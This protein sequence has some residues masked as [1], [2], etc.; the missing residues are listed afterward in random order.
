MEDEDNF[1]FDMI[2]NNNTIVENKNSIKLNKDLNNSSS[3]KAQNAIIRAKSLFK[4]KKINLKK[5]RNKVFNNNK[6]KI[7]LSEKKPSTKKKDDESEEGKI[8]ECH[9][10]MCEKVFNDKN[11]YRKHLIIHG[12]KQFVCQAEGCGK[13]FLDNSKLKRHMLVHTGLKAYKCELCNKRFSL[14]FNLR[15]HLRIHTGEKPYVCSFEGC[16]KRFSQSSNLSAHEKTH[17]LTKLEEANNNTT[18]N[19]FNLGFKNNLN[20]L[21]DANNTNISYIHI[22]PANI[23]SFLFPHKRKL[24]KICQ[25]YNEENSEKHKKPAV[26]LDKDRYE[27]KLKELED[28]KKEFELIKK[29]YLLEKTNEY[30]ERHNLLAFSNNNNNDN[31]IAESINENIYS[32]TNNNTTKDNLVNQSL[33]INDSNVKDSDENNQNNSNKTNKELNFLLSSLDY[34]IEKRINNKHFE[35]QVED[36]IDNEKVCYYYTREYALKQLNE[37]E[38]IYKVKL[39]N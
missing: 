19:S 20:N 33:K 10:P 32:D 34:N 4:G 14:D 11:S 28:K 37:L 26:I 8:Y 35:N 16:Y 29:K 15:T 23:N 39:L 6:N 25:K 27:E 13:K 18:G 30:I 22:N 9:H 1:N 7:K 21:N 17:Y 31:D 12:E 3:I 38:K 36:N 24:F 5:K 2:M